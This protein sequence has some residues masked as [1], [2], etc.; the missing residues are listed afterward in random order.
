MRKIIYTNP[1]GVSLTFSDEGHYKITSL[2]GT[3][4]PDETRDEQEIPFI[5]GS[6]TISHVQKP[7]KINMDFLLDSGNDLLLQYELRRELVSILN[8]KLGEGSLLYTNEHGTWYIEALPLGPEFP[9]KNVNDSTQRATLVFHCAD[10][11]WKDETEVEVEVT[12]ESGIVTIDN[13]GDAPTSF[14]LVLSGTGEN[15]VFEERNQG[16]RIELP[17][18]NDK[19]LAIDS[20]F[21]GKSVETSVPRQDVFS[22]AYLPF[23][24]VRYSSHLR[25]L[26]FIRGT[27][28]QLLSSYDGKKLI[29]R[30]YGK[31]YTETVFIDALRKWVVISSDGTVLESLTGK[32]WT[33]HTRTHATVHYS[34]AYSPSLALY[35]TVGNTG[36]IE[37]STDL[38]TWTTR[39]SGTTKTLHAIAWCAFLSLFVVVGADGTILSSPDGITWTAETSGTANTLYAIA[40]NGVAVCAAG[41]TGTILS[42]TNATS[43]TTETSGTTSILYDIWYAN[44][45]W[46]A[47]GASSVI[48]TSSDHVTWTTVTPPSIG[49]RAFYSIAYCAH[50]T[51]YV[52]TSTDGIRV[53]TADFSTWEI[54]SAIVAD[55]ASYAQGFGYNPSTGTML[56]GIGGSVARH[57]RSVDDGLTWATFS[58]GYVLSTAYSASLDIWVAVGQTAVVKWSDDDG[59]TWTNGTVGVSS[60][61]RV[62]WVS[63]KS[64]FVAC[65]TDIH[66]SRDGKT[67]FLVEDTPGSMYALTYSEEQERLCCV[68]ASG[69]VYVSD[70]GVHWTVVPIPGYAT[71]TWKDVAFSSELLQW[72]AVAD[73]GLIAVSY[74]A[75]SWSVTDISTTLFIF[76]SITYNEITGRWEAI[77]I[78]EAGSGRYCMFIS[79]DGLT[80][81]EDT[82]PSGYT[83]GIL[84]YNKDLGKA[85]FMA[86]YASLYF[87]EQEEDTS[88]LSSLSVDSDLF[89][90]QK[91]TNRILLTADGG[92]EGTLSYRKRY[93]GV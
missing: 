84:K 54:L 64:M 91:G 8:P 40:E 42:S 83:R 80:W 79:T 32:E 76:S 24:S 28:Y 39:T 35:C 67:F 71:T 89:S 9:N 86:D 77:G 57:F 85:V 15:L 22:C 74:D 20:A 37:T 93:I 18:W 4:Y 65:G 6:K 21:G 73:G 2:T 10:P 25:Q 51:K 82:P 17:A 68:G 3:G 49:S 38:D 34:I 60:L 12:T 70:D 56:F 26:L 90:L 41:A 45:L 81:T 63:S 50:E 16:K 19:D 62:L 5:D 43:W 13:T 75:L 47:V 52:L 87:I 44:S 69:R 72:C 1:E 48:R 61:R 27:G 58:V 88:I 30:E 66:I 55:I 46:L 29:A 14:S 59:A 36:L 31:T 11:Y 78:V 53:L 92:Y 23:Y 7:R 33:E